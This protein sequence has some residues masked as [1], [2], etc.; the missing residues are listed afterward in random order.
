M[1][2]KFNVQFRYVL[3]LKIF[4][5]AYEMTMMAYYVGSLCFFFIN[6]YKENTC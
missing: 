1:I 5:I 3:W 2:K 4:A 6:D